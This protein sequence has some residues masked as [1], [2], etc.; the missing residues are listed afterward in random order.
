MLAPFFLKDADDFEHD[1]LDADILAQRVF[2]PEKFLGHRL[3]DD[4]HAPGLFHIFL[5]EG[6]ASRHVIPAFDFQV[7][8]GTSLYSFRAPVLVAVNDLAAGAHHGGSP[9]DHG[10]VFRNGFAVRVGQGG[11]SARAG[12]DAAFGDGSRAD[13]Q[14]VRPPWKRWYF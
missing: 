13:I 6:L 14:R 5:G 11:P 4:A 1:I 12:I 9:Q 7:F 2:V 10:A 3:A 8:H